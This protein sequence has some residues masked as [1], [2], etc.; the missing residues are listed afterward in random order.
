MLQGGNV[1]CPTSTDHD[2]E[3]PR[4][5]G[6]F[7]RVCANRSPHRGVLTSKSSWPCSR[8]SVPP[9]GAME[10]RAAVRSPTRSGA[11]NK[12]LVNRCLRR[13][14]LRF[15]YHSQKFCISIR[16]A[17][18]SSEHGRS[19]RC[20]P[21]MTLVA[22]RFLLTGG[23]RRIS[24]GSQVTSFSSSARRGGKVACAEP[25][26]AATDVTERAKLRTGAG[27]ADGSQ[28]GWSDG[29]SDR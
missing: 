12:R 25:A 7:S 22:S 23:P 5:D 16:I 2:P 29:A 8:G 6:L 24:H 21:L 18:L 20:A 15:V 28:A 1:V 9:L 17:T 26:S 11:R 4:C 27:F 19:P 14:I 10:A 13:G 3:H